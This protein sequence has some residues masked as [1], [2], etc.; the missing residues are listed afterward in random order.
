MLTP[1]SWPRPSYICKSSREDSRRIRNPWRCSYR[2]LYR[3]LLCPRHQ[4]HEEPQ[5]QQQHEEQELSLARQC[6][7]M[8]NKNMCSL[9]PNKDLGLPFLPSFPVVVAENKRRNGRKQVGEF[10]RSIWNERLP[11][12]SLSSSQP[13]PPS[14]T[15]YHHSQHHHLSLFLLS[16]SPEIWKNF[17]WFV[18]SA[19]FCGEKK[20]LCMYITFETRF[21]LMNKLWNAPKG[22]EMFTLALRIPVH[23]CFA[24]NRRYNSKSLMCD[25]VTKQTAT[26]GTRLSSA[27]FL[28]EKMKHGTIH[29]KSSAI[30]WPHHQHWPRKHL[31]DHRTCASWRRQ[32]NTCKPPWQQAADHPCTPVGLEQRREH[33]RPGT[34]D[35]DQYN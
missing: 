13:A 11:H 16:Q 34:F 1:R 4:Q 7:W 30:P 17:Q 33:Q 31:K 18:C 27:E 2:T 25:R 20:M 23:A 29:G 21:G 32:S 24:P 19:N 26:R 22:R 5:Q 35:S 8:K 6:I 15:F 10:R 3:L 28:R 9:I 12:L 14:I